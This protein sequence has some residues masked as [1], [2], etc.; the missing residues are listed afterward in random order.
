MILRAL[1]RFQHKMEADIRAGLDNGEF[2]LLF[3]IAG[4]KLSVDD[5]GDGLTSLSNLAAFSPADLKLN[6]A[7]NAAPS[8]PASA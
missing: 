4:I 7:T 3:Q 8:G 1:H 5:S 2:F 6:Q